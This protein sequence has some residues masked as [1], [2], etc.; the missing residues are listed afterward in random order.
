MIALA[1]AV[2]IT[3][4]MGLKTDQPPINTEAPSP[5]IASPSAAIPLQSQSPEDPRPLAHSDDADISNNETTLAVDL[6]QALA[7][8]REIE[9]PD[10]AEKQMAALADSIAPEDR[11][12]VLNQLWSEPRPAWIG[13]LGLRL[14]AAWSQDTPEAAAAWLEGMSTGLTRNDKTG[15]AITDD[16]EVR[17]LFEQLVSAWAQTDPEAADNRSEPATFKVI[18]ELAIQ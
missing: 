13:D 9:D 12:A 11:E 8:I 5:A 17:S 18:S 7:E 14:I 16:P 15:R 3:I 4:F 10:E 1:S 6:E 2:G